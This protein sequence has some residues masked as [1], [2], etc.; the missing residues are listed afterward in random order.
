MLV[1]VSD[2]NDHSYY[3]DSNNKIQF[4]IV[5]V[6]CLYLFQFTDVYS[7]Q[8]IFNSFHNDSRILDF[9]VII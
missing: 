2:T 5:Y 1:Q 6:N 8:E 4:N 3:K 7:A 9:R